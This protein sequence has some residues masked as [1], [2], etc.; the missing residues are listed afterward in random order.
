MQTLRLALHGAGPQ[1]LALAAHDA[2]RRDRR[3]G[4]HRHRRDRHRRA[5]RRSPT[6]STAWA[7]NLIV[8][9]PGSAQTSGARTGNGGA[10]TLTAGDGLAIAKLPGVAARLAVG[11]R[12][13][14]VVANGQNWQ[15]AVTG[16]APTYTSV[17]SRGRSHRAVLHA[18]RDRRRGEGRR[19]RANGRDATLS[20]TAAIRSAR[21][22]ADQERAVHRHRH[23][24]RERA[25]RRRPRSGRHRR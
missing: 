9:M 14:A 13:H 10:S 18:S 21:T 5:R 6:R 20:P 3:R 2:R 4:G 24:Q 11:Q 25:E 22:I 15:T 1:P 19:A 17:R 23:A 12:A 16:V 7:R 8:V